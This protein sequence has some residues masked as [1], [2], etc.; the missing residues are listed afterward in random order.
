MIKI[1]VYSKDRPMQLDLALRSTAEYFR[2]PHMTDVLWT[3][4]NEEYEK[5]YKELFKIYKGNSYFSNLHFIKQTNF[6]NDTLKMINADYDYLTVIGDDVVFNKPITKV[7]GEVFEKIFDHYQE[8]MLAVNYRLGKNMKGKYK[9]SPEEV[10]PV[11]MAHYLTHLNLFY[12][13][14][15]QMAKRDGKVEWG[16]PMNLMCQFY[17]RDDIVNYWPNLK[18]NCPNS[19]EGAMMQNII[20]K[21]LMVCFEESK[22]LEF[23]LNIVQSAAPQNR[24]GNTTTKELND[25]W[26]D[27]YRISFEAIEVADSSFSR[28]LDPH[29]HLIER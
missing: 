15:W 6:R 29:L 13:W 3:A 18:F 25:I 12:I 4:T 16:Y 2:L 22:V 1:I 17:R 20:N 9:D 19:L 23:C 10:P 14:N 27:S 8:E 28:H 26:L 5:G 24:H 7:D 11:F 21:P